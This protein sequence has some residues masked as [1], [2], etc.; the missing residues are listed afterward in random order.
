M[1]QSKTSLPFA[2]DAT[3]SCI[4]ELIE[5]CYS[6]SAFLRAR[7]SNRFSRDAR[8]TIDG[9][10]NNDRH[11]TR[12][13]PEC[14]LDTPR[15]YQVRAGCNHREDLVLRSSNNLTSFATGPF[16][17]SKNFCVLS[18][19]TLAFRS[20]GLCIAIR[21]QPQKTRLKICAVSISTKDMQSLEK[22]SAAGCSRPN[23]RKRPPDVSFHASIGQ[24]WRTK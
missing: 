19:T 5:D 6:S 12:L 14:N 15:M 18:F 13:D 24:R 7:K 20:R 17:K 2:L 4:G 1:M 22:V 8:R 3:Q 11:C 21:R 23:F 10:I 9:Q 16:S